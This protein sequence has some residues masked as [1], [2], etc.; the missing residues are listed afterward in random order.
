MLFVLLIGLQRIIIIMK[1]EKLEK[2][3]QGKYLNRIL[4]LIIVWII[5]SSYYTSDSSAFDRISDTNCVIYE[6]LTDNFTSQKTNISEG[7]TVIFYMSAYFDMLIPVISLAI[8]IILLYAIH[9]N[10]HILSETRRK[11]E[12]AI[13]YQNLPLFLYFIVRIIGI[14]LFFLIQTSDPYNEYIMQ[15]LICRKS[16]KFGLFP[17]TYTVANWKRLRKMLVCKCWKNRVH[18]VDLASTVS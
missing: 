8:H 4:I 17:I 10:R 14:I 18:V 9:K 7:E 16:S 1:F 11:S 15:S 3:V 13:I 6:M 2:Y 12:L 5:A